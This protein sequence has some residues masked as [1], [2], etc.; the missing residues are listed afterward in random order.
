MLNFKMQGISTGQ[1]VFITVLVFI[2]A[3]SIGLLSSW[4]LLNAWNIFANAA[5]FHAVIPINW[6]TVI[7]S[8][9]IYSVVRSIFS[10]SEK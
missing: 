7:G 6:A 1:V 3:V 8:Y 2:G 5:A 4:I 9:L 10:R